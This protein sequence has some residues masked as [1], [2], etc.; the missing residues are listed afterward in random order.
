MQSWEEGTSLSITGLL[1]R[2]QNVYAFSKNDGVDIPSSFW[3]WLGI[4][5]IVVL[6]FLFLLLSNLFTGFR[7]LNVEPEGYR[8]NSGLVLLQ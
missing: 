3:T 5:M 8:K 7:G 2:I 1:A 6:L 4:P